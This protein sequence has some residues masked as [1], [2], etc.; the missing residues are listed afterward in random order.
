MKLT[1]TTTVT[2][3][4]FADIED[5]TGLTVRDLERERILSYPSSSDEAVIVFEARK[6]APKKRQPLPQKP[7][8]HWIRDD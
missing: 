6:T 7:E 3:K 5:Q 1:M 2:K 4:M 8:L